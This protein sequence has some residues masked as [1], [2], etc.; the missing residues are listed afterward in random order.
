[1]KREEIIKALRQ[2]IKQADWVSVNKK[3]PHNGLD[4]RVVLD[5]DFSQDYPAT[6]RELASGS[7]FGVYDWNDCEFEFYRNVTHWKEKPLYNVKDLC[8]VAANMLEQDVPGWISV[9]DKLPDKQGHYLIC[10]SINYWHGGCWDTNSTDSTTEGYA[11][12]TMSVL[13]CYIDSTHKWNRVF[14]GHVTHWMPLPEP[15]KEEAK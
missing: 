12:T 1:M 7:G 9:K 5:D 3:L 14:S 11:G 4:C 13:D 6:Y 10:T 2:S 15:P 8:R